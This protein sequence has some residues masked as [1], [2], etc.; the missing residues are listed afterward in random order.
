LRLEVPWGS[1]WGDIGPADPPVKP[2]GKPRRTAIFQVESTHSPSNRLPALSGIRD[3]AN[4]L[5]RVGVV[6]PL[7]E[8]RIRGETVF[9]KAECLQRTGSFKLRG[10]WWRLASIPEARRHAGVVAFSSGNHAQGV[11]WA[12]QRLKMPAVIVMPRDAPAAK[13]AGTRASGAEIVFYDRATESRETIAAELAEARGAVLVP[14]FDDPW[15]VEGQGTAGLEIV[16]QYR[17][18]TGGEVARIAVC[19]GG[20]GLSAGI[21]LGAPDAAIVVVEPE[22]WNDM[23]E[24]LKRGAIVPVGPNPPATSCDALQTLRVADLTFAILRDRGATGIAV[25]EAEIADA[26]RF[27][28]ETLKLV[29]EPGGAVALAAALAGKLPLAGTVLVVSGGNVDPATFREMTA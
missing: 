14:S 8:T 16:D 28:F 23:G 6:T 22:G 25:S 17:A 27:A 1:E 20:G 18:A 4:A 2:W 7:I 12:A 24:S 21:A 19:C 26:M 10:A 3:A 11:A 15:I 13:V 5:S 9:V 29:V